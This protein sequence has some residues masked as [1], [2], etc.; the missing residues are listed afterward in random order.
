MAAV[1]LEGARDRELTQL[2]PHHVLRHEDRHVL[3]AIM[4]RE[5]VPDHRR[6]D[7]G[8][9]RPG[10]D[11]PLLTARVHLVD[12]F[13]QFG[14]R[15]RT[16]LQR[17]R[18]TVAL[19]PEAC[20]SDSAR[21]APNSSSASPTWRSELLPTPVTCFALVVVEPTSSASGRYT[22]PSPCCGASWR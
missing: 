16:L 17:S 9:A 15:V 10:L 21:V 22:C 18:H 11:D 14:F 6:E 2:V 3:A 7:G 4:H 8:A 19:L 12:S 20:H 1:P 13:Q 5:R